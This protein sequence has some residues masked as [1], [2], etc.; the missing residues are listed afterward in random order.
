MNQLKR[1]G[2]GNNFNELYTDGKI[3]F[4][5]SKNHYGN[6]KILVIQ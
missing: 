2:Y 5:K 1:F 6:N 3:I 4:K